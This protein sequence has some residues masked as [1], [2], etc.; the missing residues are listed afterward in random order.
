MLIWQ[1]HFKYYRHKSKQNRRA[2]IIHSRQIIEY[3]RK[4]IDKK[5]RYWRGKS[6]V[7]FIHNRYKKFRT[8]FMFLL[9]RKPA[10]T[11][12][13]NFTSVTRIIAAILFCWLEK[14]KKLKKMFVI[15]SFQTFYYRYSQNEI[16]FLRM[17]AFSFS[18][19]LSR[20]KIVR[21]SKN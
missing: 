11:V 7:F 2:R 10:V 13:A 14:K 9:H 8:F 16:R 17:S 19:D 5:K 20:Y 12:N 18:F 4:N 3:Y 21:K 15:F 1:T 6:E